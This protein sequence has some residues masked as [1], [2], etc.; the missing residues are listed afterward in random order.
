MVLVNKLNKIVKCIFMDGVTAKDA[1]KTSYF[2]IWK[3]HDFFNF[4]ILTEAECS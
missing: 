3:N 1:A 4:M 2:H